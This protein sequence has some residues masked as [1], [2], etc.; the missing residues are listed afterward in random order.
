LP[1]LRIDPLSGRRV[2][3]AGERGGRPG[4]FLD[5]Q[6]AAPV[7]PDNDPF[8]EGHEDRTPPEVWALRPGGGPPD[9]WTMRRSSVISP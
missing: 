5:V 6:P 2:I 7:E 3:V 1:E 8:L 4:A 9:S